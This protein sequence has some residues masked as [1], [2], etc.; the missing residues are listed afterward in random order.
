MYMGGE[1]VARRWLVLLPDAKGEQNFVVLD[2][3]R[4]KVV[5]D[6]FTPLHRAAECGHES[7]ARYLVSQG[8]NIEART[9]VSDARDVRL[10]DGRGGCPIKAPEWLDR[11]EA[12]AAAWHVD[13]GCEREAFVDVVVDAVSVQAGWTPLHQAAEFA[14]GAVVTY[15]VSQGAAINAKTKVSNDEAVLQLRSCDEGRCSGGRREQCL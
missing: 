6:G 15:L 8:A 4:F 7:V 2:R 11:R 13:T 1:V 10:S 14:Q 5:Q 12:G 9:N 3:A